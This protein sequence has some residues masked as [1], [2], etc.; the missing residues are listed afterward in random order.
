MLVANVGAGAWIALVGCGLL[1][2]SMLWLLIRMREEKI[3]PPPA[4]T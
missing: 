4:S 1:A 3:P 2:A